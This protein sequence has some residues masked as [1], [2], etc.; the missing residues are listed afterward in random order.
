MGADWQTIKTEYITTNIGYRALAKKY[1]V[2][3]TTL[4]ERG[5]NEQWVEQKKRFRDETL[6]KTLKSISEQ[7]IDNA[8]K[9]AEVTDKLVDLV[10]GALT[11]VEAES[12]SAKS[13]RALT[14]A[15]KELGEILGIKTE[16]DL[17]EQS[18]RIAHLRKQANLEEP[19]PIKLIVEGLPEEFKA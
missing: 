5:G 11:A 17:E 13:L 3:F 1:D 19:K 14:A 10:N 8:T 2:P 4:A 16:L 18:A 7:K 6:T 12:V 15:V 9:Y